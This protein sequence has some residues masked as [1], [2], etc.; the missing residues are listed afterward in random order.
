MKLLGLRICEHDA[1]FTLYDNGRVFYY[2]PERFHQVKHKA[3]KLNEWEDEIKRVWNITSKDLDHIAIVFDPWTH[4]LSD[5][6]ESFF[7]A[8]DYLDFK[9]DCKV[10]RINHHY[11]HALSYWPLD[12]NPDVSIVIDGYGDKD[13]AWTVFRK[14]NLVEEGS[15]KTHGSIGFEMSVLGGDMG[16][17]ADHY[18][19]IAGK[20]MGLQSY[21]KVDQEYKKFLSKYSIY[22]VN[23]IFNLNFWDNYKGDPLLGELTQLDAVATIHDYIGDVLVKF[24]KTYCNKNDT[25]FYAGGVAQNV[26]W[27]TKL[28]KEFPNLV[29]PPHCADEGLSLGAIEYLRREYNLPPFKLEGFPY[30]QLDS[31][32]WHEI[33]DDTIAQVAQELANGKVIGWF[34]GRGEIGP[35]ALGNR[36]IL[37]DPTVTN[38]KDIINKFK[39]REGYRP[40]GASI[41]EEHK[42]LYFKDLPVNPYMLYVGETYATD[43]LQSISHVDGTCRAQTVPNN[44][45]AFRKLLQEFFNITG[46]P[47]LLNTSLNLAGKPIACTPID[48][49]EFFKTTEIDCLVIGNDIFSR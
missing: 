43:V 14:D 44:D 29:I 1:N 32:E 36:S 23:E 48:A 40:F 13:K 3:F 28:K 31:H 47:I 7:P 39:R 2:K 5:N 25:V 16:I 10:T 19:D 42:D 45:T 22:S 21:G 26:I 4:N 17:R 9:A 12:V 8:V 30:C 24:F 15:K 6:N 37:F 41:L 33:T 35:R 46:C 38:G 49:M 18:V 20:L 34:Q 27:N 11:A